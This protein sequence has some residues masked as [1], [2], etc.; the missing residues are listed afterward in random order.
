MK[1]L[2]HVLAF[3]LIL[4]VPVLG[5]DTV[6]NTYTTGNFSSATPP[7]N[8]SVGAGSVMNM[9][10]SAPR[11]PSDMWAG[12]FGNV[13]ANYIV[14]QD[15]QSPF[16]SWGL[17]DARYVYASSQPLD[18]SGDW[19]PGNI[20]YMKNQYSFLGTGSEEPSETFKYNNGSIDSGFQEDPVNDTLMSKTYNGS[21]NPYWKTLY[22]SD[23]GGGFF[24]GPVDGGTS[25]ND[26]A[27]DYQLILPEEGFGDGGTEYSMYLELE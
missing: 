21:G 12:V 14:G 6:N 18:F 1:K 17:L 19:S 8:E 24:A 7:E 15:T 3:F 9:N 2:L 27:A 10:V 22:L 20:S 13:T 11:A 5:Q 23:G 25:F 26:L 16:F 4:S